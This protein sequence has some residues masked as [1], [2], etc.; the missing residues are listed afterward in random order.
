[1]G[2]GQIGLS[3]LGGGVAGAISSISLGTGL[4]R[5]FSAFAFWGIGSTLCGWISGSVIS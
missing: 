1:M 3:A 5:G 4:V 2:L